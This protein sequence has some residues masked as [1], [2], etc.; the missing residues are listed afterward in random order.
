MKRVI[1]DA[2]PTRRSIRPTQCFHREAYMFAL[3]RALL[4]ATAFAAL[5]APLAAHEPG[6]LGKV[7]FSTSCAPAAQEKFNLAMAY[8]H[9]FWYRAAYDTYQETLKIDPGCAM[10]YW[11]IALTRRSNPFTMPT[12]QLLAEGLAAIDTALALPP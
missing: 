5:I 2:L 1:C 3:R 10:A 7:N 11:G 6:K 9:S 12:P 4:A 8:Q